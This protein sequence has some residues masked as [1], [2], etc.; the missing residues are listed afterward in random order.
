M[1][2]R[3]ARGKLLQLSFPLSRPCSTKPALHHRGNYGALEPIRY[4][5]S[6][7]H[8]ASQNVAPFGKHAW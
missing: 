5:D 1:K 2:K 6:S 8:G 7:D 4:S 3:A